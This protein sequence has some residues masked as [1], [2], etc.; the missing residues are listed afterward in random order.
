MRVG[1]VWVFD[2]VLANDADDVRNA[3]VTVRRPGARTTLAR[4]SK[5]F[6]LF[7]GDLDVLDQ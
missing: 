4:S 7:L 5:T 2:S 1:A 3:A 6:D